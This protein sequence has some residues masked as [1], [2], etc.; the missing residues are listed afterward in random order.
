M[1]ARVTCVLNKSF[2]RQMHMN[3]NKQ[4]Q[5]AM[6]QGCGRLS[7]YHNGLY[8]SV[9]VV[10]GITGINSFAMHIAAVMAFFSWLYV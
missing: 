2:N 4:K 6:L 3:V 10:D 7:V 5:V 9:L 8:S 1:V